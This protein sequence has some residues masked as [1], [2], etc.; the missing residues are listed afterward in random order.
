MGDHKPTAPEVSTWV[1]FTLAQVSLRMNDSG[2][3]R[4]EWETLQP[5]PSPWSPE[6]GD[7]VS[8]VTK[9]DMCQ[10][11][12]FE[13]LVE[14]KNCHTSCTVACG[15]AF[16]ACPNEGWFEVEKC[17]TQMQLFASW[18]RIPANFPT[19][20]GFRHLSSLMCSPWC[21]RSRTESRSKAAPRKS[22]ILIV[23]LRKE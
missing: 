16:S 22:D 10:T 5:L 6:E 7:I 1:Y 15:G 11:F 21:W 17:N 4:E 12:A 13:S 20:G 23:L 14:K 2:D 3:L 8:V 19:F 18:R 9:P